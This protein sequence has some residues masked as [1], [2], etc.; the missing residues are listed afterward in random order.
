MSARAA[1]QARAAERDA[2]AAARQA[3]GRNAPWRKRWRKC[4]RA[5]G[6]CL[7]DALAAPLVGLLA[8][9]WKVEFRGEAGAA[10]MAAEGPK[11]IMAWHGRLLMAMPLRGHRD[12]KFVVLVSP[13]ADGSLVVTSLLRFG[14]QVIR[15]SSSRGG[16]QALRALGQALRG[17]EAIVLT[18]DGPRGPRHTVNSGVGW[19]ARASGAPIVPVAFA[20]DRAWRLRSWD[21]FTIPKPFARI[22]V[23]YLD[24]TT[25]AR[26]TPD[27]QLEAL[28]QRLGAE[29]VAAELAAFAAL[30][31]P[32][33]H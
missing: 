33:D 21:R 23:T 24:P 17:G 27:E 20:V 2:I 19:L 18:P 25:V 13:S 14:Y 3:E 32:A 8:R 1:R 26:G 9:T 6:K 15:G 16:A 30:A 7:L 22:V 5:V 29:L 11:V 12:R 10:A 28:G 4:R 31:V